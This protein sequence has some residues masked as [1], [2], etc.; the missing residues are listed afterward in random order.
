MMTYKIMIMKNR[1]KMIIR[2][3]ER[4]LNELNFFE[5]NSISQN[6]SKDLGENTIAK[7][8]PV[9]RSIKMK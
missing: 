7:K 8:I 2:V 6:S 3:I 1:M 5:D 4:S 9:M